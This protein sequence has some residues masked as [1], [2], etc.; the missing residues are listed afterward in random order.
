M[1]EVVA[2]RFGFYLPTRGITCTPGPLATLVQRAEDWGFSSTMISDHVVF[3]VTVN[4]IYPYTASGKLPG[5]GDAMEQLSLLA[6]L[7]AKTTKLR[8]VTSILIVP[9]RN[10]VLAAKTLATIDV[11]SNGRL[12]VGV[13]VGWMRE[14]FEAM[15]SHDYDRR[16]AVTD[17]YMRI[18]KL[19]WTQAPVSFHGEFYR[20]KKDGPFSK[21]MNLKRK[22]FSRRGSASN[23]P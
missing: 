19:L 9:Q 21:P 5:S 8:L 20:K 12:T 13:G 18:Y 16:G 22:R 15:G 23:I 10:P 1:E 17:E 2:V 7:A 14:E 11:L 6:F 4:S 3:P